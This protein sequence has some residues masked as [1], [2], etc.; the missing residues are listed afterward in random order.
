MLKIIGITGGVGSGK[1]TVLSFLQK[2]YDAYIIMADEVG[3]KLMEPDGGCFVQIVKAFGKAVLSDDGRLDR[4]MLSKRIFSNPEDREILDGI[5]HP[6]VKEEIYSEI[7]SIKNKY[8]GGNFLVVIEAALLIEE[9]YDL[10]CDELWYIYSSEKSRI[11]RLKAS[12]GYSEDK[13]LS[14][15]RNQLSDEM[16][17][18]FCAVTIDNSG[19]FEDTKRQLRAEYDRVMNIK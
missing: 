2:E 6:A 17:R 7:E 3:R 4:E 15:M 16:M 1:S 9:G 19:D 13:S 5:V 11:A 12:R 14:I 18:K 8:R 10:V